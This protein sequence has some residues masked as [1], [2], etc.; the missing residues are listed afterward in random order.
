MKKLILKCRFCSKI[1]GE[2]QYPDN[3]SVA[4][5]GIADIRC[6]TC[7]GKYGSFK[8]MADEFTRDIDTYNKFKSVMIK[9]EYKRAKFD[10]EVAKIQEAKLKI[11]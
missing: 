7:E 1:T 4:D 5:L 3:L 9:S 2:Y 11:K 6:E 10:L 8:E